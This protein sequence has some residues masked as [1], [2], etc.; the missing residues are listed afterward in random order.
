[1]NDVSTYIK[2]Y[3]IIYNGM[4]YI[5]YITMIITNKFK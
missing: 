5:I 4:V 1:M 3:L 2:I